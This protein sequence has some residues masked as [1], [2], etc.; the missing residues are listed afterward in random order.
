MGSALVRWYWGCAPHPARLGR[1][2]PLCQAV[3]PQILAS[4]P[5]QRLLRLWTQDRP[6]A[7]PVLPGDSRHLLG[8]WLWV[9]GP[10]QKQQ[11][12]LDQEINTRRFFFFLE[13]E[14]NFWKSYFKGTKKEIKE[15][16]TQNCSPSLD[17]ETA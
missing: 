9:R 4:L 16:K 10:L 15:I 8:L 3:P 7:L 1:R 11:I 2:V 13:C 17:K 12:A 5:C 14:T 6:Q